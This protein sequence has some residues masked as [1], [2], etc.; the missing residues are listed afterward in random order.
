M[1]DILVAVLKSGPRTFEDLVQLTG[2]SPD[3]IAERLSALRKSLGEQLVYSGTR[4]LSHGYWRIRDIKQVNRDI[5]G[6][7]TYL[8]LQALSRQPESSR[9]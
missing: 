2:L 4:S 3:R 7:L 1:Q 8:A 5:P 6:A 9:R